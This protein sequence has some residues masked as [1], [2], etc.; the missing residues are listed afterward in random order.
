MHV[1]WLGR[2]SR[3]GNDVCDETD[4]AGA[5]H[6]HRSIDA[7][8]EG[9]LEAWDWRADDRILHTL[10]LH[11]VHGIVNALLCAHS[12]GACVEFLPAFSPTKVWEHLMVSTPYENDKIDYCMVQY[13]VR[14][15]S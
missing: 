8:I 7:Q 11:H 10:P 6:T 9:M 14:Q 3:H 15:I 1:W 4:V 12:A 13:I 5:L 2:R